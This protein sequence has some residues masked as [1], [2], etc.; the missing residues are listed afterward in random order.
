MMATREEKNTF[1]MMILTRAETLQTD[2]MDA[3]LTHCEEVG[4]E[5]EVAATLINDVLLSKIEEEA[6]QINVIPRSAKLPL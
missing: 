1:S 3:I 4:L 2:H 6:Q 5:V